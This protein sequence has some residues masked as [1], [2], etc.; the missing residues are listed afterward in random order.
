ML[1]NRT[2]L[3]SSAKRM[4]WRHWVLLASAAALVA[5]VAPASAGTLLL[6]VHAPPPPPPVRLAVGSL[7]VELD[8]ETGNLTSAAILTAD[9][10]LLEFLAGR[11]HRQ[12]LVTL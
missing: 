1:E 5:V 8:G 3:E 4:G 7:R 11:Q 9:A 12:P 10:T 2:P 6:D